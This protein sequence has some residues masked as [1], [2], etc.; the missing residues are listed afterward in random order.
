MRKAHML[1]FVICLFIAGQAFSQITISGSTGTANGTYT[2]FTNAGGAF[3]ALNTGGSHNAGDA[4][5]ISITTDVTTEAGTVSLNAGTWASVNITPAGARTISG[6]PAAGTPLI[7]LNGA[8]NVTI[9]GLN[10]GG[11][12]L[13][14]SNL[15]TGTTAGTCTI[16]FIADASTNTITRC[17]ILGSSAS[18]LATVAGTI[19]FS[20]GTTTGNDN[21]TISSC[22]IGP[23]GANLPSKAIMASG[24]SS[25]IE[26]DNVQINNNNIYDFFLATSSLSGI[27]ILTG[28]EGWTISGNKFYQTATRTFTN[29]ALRYSAITL[30][31]TTGSYTISGNT[32]GFAAANGTGV[33]TIT[34]SSN[35]FRGIDATS[36]NTTP[37]TSIQG[38]TISGINQTSSRASISTGAGP[39]T[40][41]ATG[42]TQGFFD[43][44]GTTG[45]TIGSLDGSSTIVV[46]A[47]STTASTTPVIGI[48]DWSQ[49]ATV[50]SN[51]RVGSITINSGGSGTVVG[52]RGI[53]VTGT[54]GVT[55]TVNSNTI[56]GTAAG[57]ITDN[58]TGSYAMYG[59][60]CASSNATMTGNVVR[61]MAGNSNGA[62]LIVSSGIT[63]SGSTGVNSFSQ[64]TIH[65]LSNASGSAAN[66]I[67][68]LSLT[69]P[70]TANIIERNLIHSFSITSTATTSQLWGIYSGATG[71]ATYKNNMI[72]LG[73]DASGNAITTG[74]SIIGIRDATGVTNN[75]YHNSVYIGGSGVT[76]ASNSYCFYSDVVTV[77]RSFQNNIFWNA[78]GNS[79]AGGVAHLAIRV[80]GTAA[81]PAGL[82]CN[83]NDLYVSGTDGAIGVFNSTVYATIAAWRTATG[84][85]A[86]SFNGDPQFI[87]PAANAAS[88]DLHINPSVATVIEGTGTSVASVTDDYDGQTRSGLTPVDIGADAG[89]FT[90]AASMTYVS[91]TTTQ[92]NVTAVGTNSVN[93]QVIGIEVVT[94]GAVSPLSA[95]SF[96]VNTNGTTNVADITNAKLFYTGTNASFS[97]VNQFGSTVA[98]PSGSYSITGTQVLAEG[99]NYF[100]LTYDIPCSA[101]PGNQ[102]D[103]ECTSLTVGSAYTPTV[104]N[105]GT[106][107]A[108]TVGPLAGTY[109]VGSGGNYATLTAA[110]AA[111]N[112]IG[113]AANTTFEILGNITEPGIVTINQWIECGAGG[114]TLTIKPAASTNPVIS[115]SVTTSLISLNGARRVIID[116]SNNGTAS[117]NLTFSNT[118]TSGATI[119]FING[120]SNNTVKNCVLTGVTTSTTNGVV[121]F[122]TAGAAGNNNNL[123]QNNS[124]TK[125]TTLP[126]NGVFNLGTSAALQNTGNTITQNS[127]SDFSGQGINDGGYSSGFTYSANQLFGTATQ[128]SSTAL[129]GIFLGATTIQSPTITGNRI[130]DLKTTNTSASTGYLVGIDIYEIASGTTCIVTNNMISLYGNGTSAPGIRVAGIADESTAGTTNIYYNTISIYGAATSSNAS[131]AFLKNYLNTTVLKNNILSNT[132]TSTGSG[133]QYSIVYASGSGP[134]TADYN[135]LQSTGNALNILGSYGG[136]D[137][138]SIAAWR[139]ASAGDA[140]SVSVLPV[141]TAPTDLH[142]VTSA[143]CALD[144]AGNNTG[145]LLAD[146]FDATGVR[147]TSSPFTT[148]IGADE[149]TGNF[150]LVITN[151][152]AACGAVDIT[153]ATVTTGSSS[154]TTLSYWMDLAATTAIPAGN[155]TPSA[156]ATSGTYYIKSVK[157]SCSDVKAVNVTVN[158]R[159]TGA[160]S[161]TATICAGSAA[162]L[163]L[164]VTGSGTISGLLSDGTAY[165]GTA[166]TITV[167]V[168]PSSNTSYTISMMNDANCSA[169]AAGLT[170]SANIT[171]TPASGNLAAVAGGSQV[172]ANNVVV[173]VTGSTYSDPASC[174]LIAKILPSGASPVSGSVNTCVTID[175]SVQTY[176]VEPYVQRH[177]DIEP[178]SSP[179]TATARITLYFTDNE[180]V[181]YNGN[182]SGYKPLPTSVL[183]NADPAIANLRVNQFHGTGSVP[184][185][186]TG[187]QEVIDPADADIVWN[188]SASRWE[189]TID[190]NGFSGFYI[191]SIANVLPINISYFKGAR[192]NNAHLLSWKVNCYST[193]S[194]TLTLERS[195]VANGGFASIYSIQATAARCNQPFDHTDVQPLPGMNYYRLKMTDADGKVSYSGIVALLNAT[196]GFEIV[197]IA[198]NPVVDGSFKLNVTTAQ[199]AKID[200]VIIDM[201]GRVVQRSQE[202]LNA[203]FNSLPMNVTGLS[204]GTYSLYG[205]T[206]DGRSSTLRFVKQ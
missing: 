77:T 56:G 115:A 175:N 170:G 123:V 147:S 97:A 49:T 32:I 131:Y 204:A 149:F 42:V 101:T 18:T 136:T 5:V 164:S 55:V 23:A 155:G 47:T 108:I 28:N 91:S 188:A 96:T 82:T 36:V 128:T 65:S 63:T 17:T 122:S 102:V 176:I 21:N 33:T 11:N 15:S 196:K 194:V 178:A 67:Y 3:A 161:G 38:N 132:R 35:E 146:D 167:V 39:F 12:S 185:S 205:V 151:P 174:D 117:R 73:I 158:A 8:D 60:Q 137:Q 16:R 119:R 197:S 142:L 27:N 183:G 107:R 54:T 133:K 100:W 134:M 157:G 13:T 114:Y 88:V 141:F 165:S 98:T 59:I 72:R 44:G 195:V 90:P 4:I 113:L 109:T 110:A 171:V 6:T 83:Y 25:S 166:P 53:L 172:C 160:I 1:V 14:V 144:G 169:Q 89:N 177:Y 145:I 129:Y 70:V 168:S 138:A 200:V 48:F 19:V 152:A 186:Y 203:G 45:N 30:N 64:N 163:T 130:Y 193:P 202:A 62:S 69:L 92:S 87:A 68:G 51:N 127:I 94:T 159:P 99:T 112:S 173:P 61:N 191:T 121:F 58:I 71:T 199:A 75:Y 190:V 41:I 40:G 162:T 153:A 184:G 179:S 105:P 154:G 2:S 66:S 95:T 156:I 126:V 52:F 76:S 9:D 139:T 80:G 181:N 143:N 116:G 85:D 34:G 37:A 10:S 29:S 182:S 124:I 189:V 140:A 84:Q 206:A 104:T 57:S 118:S 150:S 7:N 46:N 22:N 74:Y 198:P 93:Q 201:Q 43:I 135:D 106:G 86:N 148:D 31:N 111:V 103:A 24:T 187:A 125:G 50:I 20:T 192:Q 79:V 81:N 180:F 26:N 78:R 120:A